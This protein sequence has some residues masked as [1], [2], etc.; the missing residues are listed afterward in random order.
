MRQRWVNGV[1]T[2]KRNCLR[3]RRQPRTAHA[4]SGT[5]RDP[6]IACLKSRAVVGKEK[7]C[8]KHDNEQRSEKCTLWCV[9]GTFS[10][11]GEQREPRAPQR[12][13]LKAPRVETQAAPSAA[14]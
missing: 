5:L 11:R 4:A 8:Y 12:N 7:K 10:H 9:A 13:P 14:P 2:G 6:L 1:K 3:V